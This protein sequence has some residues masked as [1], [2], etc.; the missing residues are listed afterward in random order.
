MLTIHT[1]VRTS[2]V[3]FAFVTC[4]F[5]HC[6]SRQPCNLVLHDC[7]FPFLNVQNHKVVR[8]AINSS[9]LVLSCTLRTYVHQTIKGPSLNCPN[10]PIPDHR[11]PQ[12][13]ELV[14]IHS[15][16]IGS[17]LAALIG[18]VRDT[19]LW[20]SALVEEACHTCSSGVTMV[21]QLLCMLGKCKNH[22]LVHFVILNS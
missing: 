2:R 8:L 5:L 16:V 15:K 3:T 14:Q 13:F 4:I 12:H 6:G 19:L 10:P 1:Y 22:S 9:A 17:T 21:I 18:E 20:H 11:C 7:H